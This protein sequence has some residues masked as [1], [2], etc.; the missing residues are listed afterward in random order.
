M[1]SKEDLI[2]MINELKY[3]LEASKSAN[4][5]IQRNYEHLSKMMVNEKKNNFQIK[6]NSNEDAERISELEGLL[7][8]AESELSVSAIKSLP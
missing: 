5:A 1:M 4:L 7:T 2:A 6:N 8:N 3:E